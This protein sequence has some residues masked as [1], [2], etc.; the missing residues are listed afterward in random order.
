MDELTRR[1]R[2]KY[3]PE[4]QRF[5]ELTPMERSKNQNSWVVIAGSDIVGFC[6]TFLDA[7]ELGYTHLKGRHFL[8][9]KVLPPS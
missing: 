7:H 9:R 5:T 2:E 1:R 3:A 6:P 4:M 8:V